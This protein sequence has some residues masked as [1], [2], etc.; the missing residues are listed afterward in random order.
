MVSKA[1]SVPVRREGIALFGR[2]IGPVAA[3]L[4]LSP[5]M[6]E[7]LSGASSPLLPVVFPP[8]IFLD[9]GLY[10]CGAVLIREAAVRWG[11]GW[12]SIL[13]LGVAFA[14]LEEGLVVST[15]TDPLSPARQALDA[16]GTWGAGP[17]GSNW[18]WIPTLSIFHAVVSIALPI[19]V[20]QLAYPSQAAARWLSGRRALVAL[21]WLGA[22][23]AVG[24]AMF[25]TG[26][27]ADGYYA[28]ISGW[29]VV[30][31]TGA[32]AGL[33]LA[34]R[35]LPARIGPASGLGR[36]PAPR[37]LAFIAG[38]AYCVYFLA[39]FGGKGLGVSPALSLGLVLTVA[40]VAAPVLM[41][42]SSRDGWS[43]RHRFAV[44][45]GVAWF[46]V[47]LSVLLGPVNLI[48]A[49]LTGYGLWRGWRWLRI[50]QGTAAAPALEEPEPES[51]LAEIARRHAATPNLEDEP[52]RRRLPFGW[53]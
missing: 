46:Y 30:V 26:A 52:R 40:V 42:F 51:A 4:V 24:R 48:V 47:G 41:W 9:L 14:C 49:V 13:A 15:F 21:A 50:G 18:V 17:D 12:P 35:Y 7:I 2:R 45:A 3:L 38:S 29:Q 1:G 27:F 6:A 22:A 44:P 36:I 32:I 31:T 10:G 39:G 37:L 43:D 20:V 28:R 11:R 53:P 8:F 33:V 25:S 5:F 16:S 19:L 34:A 23:A